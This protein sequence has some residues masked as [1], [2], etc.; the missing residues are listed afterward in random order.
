MKLF[1][2]IDAV[3]ARY[4]LAL[5]PATVGLLHAGGAAAQECQADADCGA[6]Y[7]CAVSQGG[8]CSQGP[9][10]PGGEC[11]PPVCETF[12][13][14]YCEVAPCATDADCPDS[15]RCHT[16]HWQACSDAASPSCARG[17]V[18]DA[19]PP[20]EFTCTEHT[21]SVCMERYNLPCEADADCGP[22]FDCAELISTRC[23]GG[24][25]ARP[26]GDGG[27]IFEPAPT[28]CV[29]EPTGEYY[30]KL[31][32]LPC[33]A[34]AECPQ[35]LTC[36]QDY[37]TQP[38]GGGFV[39]GGASVGGTGTPVV[40]D[41]GP[42]P[43]PSYSCKPPRYA[44]GSAGGGGVVGGTSGD[45]DGPLVDAG[46]GTPNG[47]GSGSVGGS[48][49]GGGAVGGTGGATPPDEDDEESGRGSRLGRLLRGLF[50]PGGCS[51]AGASP[52]GDLSWLAVSGLLACLARRRRG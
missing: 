50:G 23:S 51:L 29:S 32:E 34:D 33:A 43:A 15:M 38:C 48:A 16:D 31:L 21:R 17:E 37:S 41:C 28:E 6:G 35:G 9:C 12:E 13:Y 18:C 46:V 7:V 8:G 49:G 4:A 26:D 20:P 24:G 25:G 2:W 22:G 52:A 42:P 40:I 10:T 45:P 14:R 39:G 19:G 3:N 47:P 36:Q 27:F 5:L 44:G 11:P 30:C 1:D